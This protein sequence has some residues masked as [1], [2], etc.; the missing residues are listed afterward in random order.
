MRLLDEVGEH[1]FGNF[2]IGDH[3]VFHGLDGDHVARRP[4][5]H[6]FR[7]APDGDYVAAV[8]IDCNNG[9][10]VYYD[11]LAARKDQ[12]VS[13][14]QVDCQVRRQQAENRPHAVTIL[15]HVLLPPD[16]AAIARRINCR[17][18]AF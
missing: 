10:L 2:E 7:L 8:L 18:F 13:G 5:K 9:R 15:S 4:A 12:C 6:F 16:L 1:F 14:S 3:A 17:N 11:A